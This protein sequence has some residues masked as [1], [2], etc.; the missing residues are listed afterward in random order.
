MLAQSS[1]GPLGDGNAGP[2]H[3]ADGQDM[4]EAII[5]AGGRLHLVDFNPVRQS[6]REHRLASGPLPAETPKA[7]VNFL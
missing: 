7:V 3:Q 5:K 6:L 1:V 4:G 2:R